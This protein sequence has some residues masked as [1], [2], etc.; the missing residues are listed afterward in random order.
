MLTVCAWCQYV[1]GPNG[2]RLQPSVVTDER[3]SHGICRE[4]DEKQRRK[5]GLKPKE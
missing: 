5:E 3:I 2:E 4:C 1:I